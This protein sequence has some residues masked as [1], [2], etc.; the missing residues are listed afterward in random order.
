[1]KRW[2]ALLLCGFTAAALA[3][4]APGGTPRELRF[5][6]GQSSVTVQGAV[7]R[8]ERV[9]WRFGAK[10]GQ[11]A[12]LTVSAREGNAALQLWAPGA[13]LPAAAG[14]D[15]QGEPLPGAGPTDD[16][17]QWT[18]PLPASG[19]YLVVVGPTRGNARYTLTLKI[20]P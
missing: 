18:G 2:L 12:T 16:A 6:K 10:Q 14:D 19:R 11:Q 3:D 4:A 15:V 1:M 5:A 8:G 17:T 13:V 7:V 20:T 9:Y